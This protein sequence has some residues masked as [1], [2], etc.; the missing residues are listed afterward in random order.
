MTRVIEIDSMAFSYGAK[1]VLGGVDLH[2]DPGEVV[3]LLGPNGVGKTTLLEN[4]VGTLTPTA[5]RV[6]VFGQDPRRVK[7]G[8]W[9][10]VGL[11][12]QNWSDHPKW[13]V[14][15]QLAWIGAIHETNRPA[16]ISVE[17]AL[18]L[19]SLGDKESQKISSLSGGERRRLDFA[20]ALII[21]GP[22]LLLLDEPTTGLD[23][24]SK[25]QMHDVIMDR[26]DRSTTVLMTTHDLAEAEKLA[27]RII[28]LG[29][30][31]VLANGSPMQLRSAH[32]GTAE[33][34]WVADGVR[35]VHA[36]EAPEEFLQ[37]LPLD[38]ISEL[39]VTRPTLED[40]YLSIVKKNGE[41]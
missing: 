15:D 25:T 30:G 28:I 38:S 6:R 1:K 20:A 5:G 8:F 27:S 10:R 32:L 16:A 41:Q 40:A 3:C 7:A 18:E 31:K 12:Q 13:R 4:I 36:T 29:E 39:T 2:V 35:N 23:P 9:S 21:G 11:V 37:G 14:K 19:V 33:V 24:V 22:E 26:V 34:S 17:Q